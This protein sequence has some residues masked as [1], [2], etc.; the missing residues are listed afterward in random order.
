VYIND[1]DPAA[2]VASK[3][4][5][6]G[7]ATI[8]GGVHAPVAGS[9]TISGSAGVVIAGPIQVGSTKLD[10]NSTKATVFD[11]DLTLVSNAGGITVNDLPGNDAVPRTIQATNIVSFDAAANIDIAGSVFAGTLYGN[12]ASLTETAALPAITIVGDAQVNVAAT[13]SLETSSYETNADTSPNPLIGQISILGATQVNNLGRIVADGPVSID[14][15]GD[16]YLTGPVTARSSIVAKTSTGSI[17]VQGAVRATGYTY[18]TSPP[19]ALLEQRTPNIT[20][21]AS[22]GSISTSGLGTLS[23]GAAAVVTDAGSTSVFGTIRATAQQSIAFGADIDTQGDLFATSQIGTLSVDGLLRTRNV[24]DATAT[25]VAA[26]GILQSP[27][28][29]IVGKVV[30]VNSGDGD[31]ATNIELASLT[32]EISELSVVNQSADGQTLVNNNVGSAKIGPV[33]ASGNYEYRNTGTITIRDVIHTNSRATAGNGNIVIRSS[34]GG[35]NVSSSVVADVGSVSI[36]SAGEIVQR[37]GS[38]ASIFLLSGGRRYEYAVVTVDPPPGAGDVALVSAKITPYPSPPFNGVVGYISELKILDP[39]WGYFSGQRVD[40]TIT[41]DGQGAKAVG[42]ATIVSSSIEGAAGVTVDAIERVTLVNQ[43]RSELGDVSVRSSR[44]DIA[45]QSVS[46]LGGNASIDAMRGDIIIETVSARG[47]IAIAAEQGVELRDSA[48]TVAGDIAITTVN[49]DLDF[50]GTSTVINAQGGRI[51]LD[52]VNGAVLTPPVLNATD[53]VVIS[54]FGTLSLNNSITTNLGNVVAESTSG[55]VVLNSYIKA[56]GSSIDIKAKND[57]VAQSVGGVSSVLVVDGGSGYSDST[58]VTFAPPASP[59]TGVTP[60]PAY[61]RPIIVNGEIT[62]I[63]IVSPG[64]GYVDGEQVAITITDPDTPPGAGAI[65]VGFCSRPMQS[66]Y[67]KD[68][69]DLTVVGSILLAGRVQ[70]V[71]GNVTVRAQEGVTVQNSVGSTGGD[72]AFRTVNRNLDFSDSNAILSCENGGVDLMSFN[73]AIIS[74]P[75]LHTS[76]DI[77]IQSYQPL[78][79]ANASTS[80]KGGITLRSTNGALQVNANVIA[81]DRVTLGARLGITQKSPIIAREIVATNSSSDPITLAN[82]SNNAENFAASNPLGAVSYSD[83][84][85]FETGIS[86]VGPLKVEVEGVDVSLASFGPLSTVRVVSGLKYKTLSIL[87]GASGGSAVGMVEYVTTSSADN[88]AANTAFQGSLRDMIRYANDNTGSF[89]IN[90]SRKQQPQA[91]VFDED[92]YAV[93]EITVAAAL[94]QF[95]RTVT[96]D[97]GRR[98]STVTADR[99]GLR[100]N[101]TAET[102]LAFGLGSSESRVTTVAAYGFGAGSAIALYSGGNVVTDVY[103]GLMADGVT[104]VP[105]RV[106]IDVNGKTAISNIIGDKVFDEAKVNRIVGNKASGIVIRNGASGTNVSGNRIYDNLGDGIRITNAVGNVI[107]DPRAVHPDMTAADSNIIS[108]NRS[109]GILVLNSNGG[110]FATAN[111]IRN[112]RI[113]ANQGVNIGVGEG[114]GIGIRGS[115]FTVIGGPNEGAG[116]TIVNQ[117]PGGTVHGIAA[118]DSTD[119][120]IIGVGNSIGI[121]LNTMTKA[122]NSGDGINLLRSQRVEISDRNTIAGNA[123]NGISIGAGSSTVTVLGN[124]IGLAAIDPTRSDLGN[125]LSGVAITEA[126]GNSVGVGNA[127][128][129]NGF[130]GVNVT[131]SRAATLPAGNRVFGSEIFANFKDGVRINGGSGTTVGGTK[132]SDAN[133]IRGNVGSGIR[134]ERTVATGAAT[135]HLIQGNLI[136]ASVNREVDPAMG[137]GEAGIRIVASSANTI[138]AGNVVMNNAGNGIELL[139]GTGNVVGGVTAAVG[140]TIT[141]N[142]GSGIRV[143][144]ATGVP[145]ALATARAHVVGGNSIVENAADGVV[146]DGTGV[147]GLTIGQQVTATKVSGV[148]NEISGNVGYGIRVNTGAQQVSFQGNSI[149]DNLAGAISMGAGA[150]RSTAQTLSLSAAV[151]RGTGNSQS[152]TVTGRLA[153]ARYP[154]QQYSID[155]YANL[156]DDGDYASLTGYQARRYL[157][158]ATVM[159]D[160]RGNATFSLRITAPLEVGEVITAMATSLR[161]EAGS[162][163]VLSNA[164]TADLPGIPTPRF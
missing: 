58:F 136:G 64:Q 53:G 22:L 108:G 2:V 9:T 35:V 99:L 46:A 3:I 25:L 164:V 137:N 107:G 122:G 119:V 18:T 156:P 11:H 7:T 55:G 102:G 47:G 23:A 54:S 73:G 126:I 13:G 43:V 56:I 140:N 110:T 104:A 76:G 68:N 117:G 128:A 71:D 51:T 144:G 127:I 31:P 33:E 135:G 17:D 36:V 41:G 159:T 139:G 112:N 57:F 77:S 162:T 94:P 148:G 39:G 155:I 88:A 152:V 120:R 45:V 129:F 96:F 15:I 63:I 89:V 141:N 124:S 49:G 12:P 10:A 5:A 29:K 79:I 59:P 93:S 42:V 69:I 78:T 44:G 149:A 24:E 1:A 90:G 62:Q 123:G 95:S 61:G 132:A 91:M 131:N 30:A 40:V 70:A 103:A 6:A 154:Q 50:R 133:I 67:A 4:V 65:A 92:G 157:G 161:F 98:E 146:V 116:N 81:E 21:S 147:S 130:H 19:A 84:D 115:K 153:N 27:F 8:S 20:L 83:V 16:I 80:D 34:A 74:P 97:G 75:V 109:N 113:E 66:L 143:G 72:I 158:R 85:G 86:R 14:V 82:G 138:A 125:A 28:S 100:G 114:A 101:A 111:R 150:N 163:S 87:A 145:T 52:S 32:N 60:Y 134:L 121:D 160:S 142:A 106:G 38:L 37:G 105:N 26:N 151:L 48:N 118:V